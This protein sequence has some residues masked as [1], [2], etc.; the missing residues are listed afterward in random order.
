MK[1]SSF[2]AMLMGTIS[3]VLFALGI[4]RRAGICRK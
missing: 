3:S 1:K 2:V 4:S